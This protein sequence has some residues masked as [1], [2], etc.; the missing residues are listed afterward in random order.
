ME[1][2]IMIFAYQLLRKLSNEHNVNRINFDAGLRSQIINTMYE[3]TLK[4]FKDTD[5][6]VVR[7][8]LRTLAH[9]LF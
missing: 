8:A 6:T 1:S 7:N 4:A 3:D 2:E 5:P 9:R